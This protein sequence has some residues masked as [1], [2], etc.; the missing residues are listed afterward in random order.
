MTGRLPW[1]PVKL[2]AHLRNFGITEATVRMNGSKPEPGVLGYERTYWRLTFPRQEG[3]RNISSILLA[4][5]EVE[6]IDRAV[7]I[8]D[9]SL[10]SDPEPPHAPLGGVNIAAL[11]RK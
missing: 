10:H 8:L 2:R 5:A 3:V 7:K 1:F 9:F 11:L 6:Q 4:L